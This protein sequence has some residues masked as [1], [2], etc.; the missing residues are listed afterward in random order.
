MRSEVTSKGVTL[1]LIK[2]VRVLA[3]QQ[4]EDIL[5][6][7]SKSSLQEG[8]EERRGLEL[9]RQWQPSVAGVPGAE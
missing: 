4:W 2:E 5:I 8:P 6:Q 7:G 9:W 1:G 3:V